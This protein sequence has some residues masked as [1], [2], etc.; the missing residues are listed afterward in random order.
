[1]VHSRYVART[2]NFYVFPH[3]YGGQDRRF[4][5]QAS[6]L[7]FLAEHKF[8]FNKFVHEVCAGW[9]LV[10]FR[11]CSF[12]RYGWIVASCNPTLFQG[13][14]YLSCAAEAKLRAKLEEEIEMMQ[15]EALQVLLS[16]RRFPNT[17]LKKR[18]CRKPF[19]TFC[20][21]IHAMSSFWLE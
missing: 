4:T 6:S 12:F 1:M 20:P 5:C 7:E 14:G 13:I 11:H 21:R 3:S 10:F 15:N 18:P 19:P 2:W 9:L 8:N 17:E 16:L